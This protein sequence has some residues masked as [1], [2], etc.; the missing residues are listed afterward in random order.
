MLLNSKLCADA[1]T[2]N[3]PCYLAEYG[4]CIVCSRMK[5]NMGRLSSGEG[6]GTPAACDCQWQGVCIYN[7]YLQNGSGAALLGEDA[8]AGLKTGMPGEQRQN[9]HCRIQRII[10]Y[11]ED[12][13]VMQVEVPAGLA[14]KASLPGS[15]VF[16]KK[17][18]DA[19]F[20]YTP[21]SI[22]KA[23]YEAGLL[24]I[25]VQIN[26][27]KTKALLGSYNGVVELRG[28]YRNG[29]LGV[30]KLMGNGPLKVL[31]LTKG[32]G[33]APVANYIRWAAGNHHIDVIA[34]LDKINR[35]FADD[36]LA[37]A[38]FD[39]AGWSA[40]NSVEFRK[41]PLDLSWAEQ[42]KYDVIIISASDFYQHNIYVPEPKKVLSNNHTMC[43]GEGI[44][45]ACICMNE[46][47]TARRLCKECGV[48]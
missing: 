22:M 42:G 44:C 17:P 19:A 4:K 16:L 23:D 25:A 2:V 8:E 6:T 43:C 26:G 29:L 10:W 33:L 46:D 47:G 11:E 15:C 30:Q 28:I 7:E 38:G 31:C 5:G 27:P 37:A 9:I 3:C 39:G 14:E 1:G 35:R 45:G 21:L 20:F 34:D 32:L 41:L 48:R 36:V 12:L 18:D 24:Y 13:A 40:V